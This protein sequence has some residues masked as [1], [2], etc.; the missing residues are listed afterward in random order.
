[1]DINS[2]ELV[3]VYLGR[4]PD[5][6]RYSL[7]LNSKYNRIVILCDELFHSSTPNV[8]VIPIDE[9][10]AGGV[11]E[12]LADLKTRL[13][14]DGFWVKAVE[15]FYVLAAYMRHYGVERLFHAE[16][17][18]LVFNLDGIASYLDKHK[19]GL[20]YPVIDGRIAAASLMYINSIAELDAMCAYI[21]K[22]TEFKDDMRLLAEYVG[23]SSAACGLPSENSL[24]GGAPIIVMGDKCVFD[25]ASIGQFLFGVDLR[26]SS[27]P[28][29]N[30]FQNTNCR[31]ELS[32]LRFRYDG[33]AGQ[34]YIG[35][36]GDEY[37]VVNLHI[38]SKVFK[39]LFVNPEYLPRVI[40]RI[41]R[42]LRTIIAV[43]FYN[44][45]GVRH[46]LALFR[47]LCLMFQK[48]KR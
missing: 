24:N 47:K 23:K 20:Y 39:K 15:R 32:G 38:H 8:K 16:I 7:L 19:C 44:F 28:V 27:G 17:D 5:Y 36:H 46:V 6:V 43:N 29:Y 14:R 40:D 12:S 3:F 9:F 1:M 4:I 37:R 11:F 22:Q 42:G 13:F 41:N 18:N 31:M 48:I 45:R 33:V 2:P 30:R 10:Y 21:N 26:N 35:Q 34:L 25:A